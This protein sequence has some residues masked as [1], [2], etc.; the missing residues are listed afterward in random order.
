MS[1]LMKTPT[2]FRQTLSFLPCIGSRLNFSN[3]AE[4][5]TAIVPVQEVT[6][7]IERCM[8]AVGTR[9][10]HARALADNLTA[11]DHR[12]HFSHGLNRL[13]DNLLIFTTYNANA[14]SIKR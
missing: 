8:T 9:P 11:A 1:A 13:G 6:H 7:F 3:S 2:I 12:G 14:W 4:E 5:A 10:E